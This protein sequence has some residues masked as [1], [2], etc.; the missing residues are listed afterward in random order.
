MQV[1]NNI[2]RC[3]SSK[4]V[5]KLPY[6]KLIKKGDLELSD[7]I[8][9]TIKKQYRNLK[10]IS[11]RAELIK[12][13]PDF[14]KELKGIIDQ[15]GGRAP[16]LL[17]DFIQIMIEDRSS[18]A[19]RA[20]NGYF[21]KGFFN[22]QEDWE[23]FCNKWRIDYAWDRQPE[24]LEKFLLSGVS[25]TKR[26][27]YLEDVEREISIS[28]EPTT[29]LNDIISLWPEV[30][31]AQK[32]VFGGKALD[33]K[34]LSRD[35]CWYDLSKKYRFSKRQIADFW[36]KN[37]P[38]DIDRLV[39]RRF[40]KEHKKFEK[41]DDEKLLDKIKSGLIPKDEI[42]EFNED[43]KFYVTGKDVRGKM[44][45]PFMD[46]I[47]KSISNLETKI[48]TVLSQNQDLKSIMLEK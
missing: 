5:I 17:D 2:H 24:T 31:K 21:P 43:K 48:E 11:Q 22:L 42:M 40:K 3:L 41:E 44:T 34:N 20:K 8:L 35:L 23:N 38:E 9:K 14:Q 25:L 4:N 37:F 46:L 28:I 10:K 19:N 39:I 7:E 30:E 15:L 6:K 12:R 13:N 33:M 26:P 47:K 32:E 36:A 16:K 18:I 45:P 1:E 27:A 29:T